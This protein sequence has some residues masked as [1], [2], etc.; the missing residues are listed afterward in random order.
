MSCTIQY[1]F[2]SNKDQEKVVREAL[3]PLIDKLPGWLRQLD[4][5][6]YNSY[7]GD[8]NCP[9]S[10]ESIFQYR[11]AELFIYF[12]FFSNTPEQ[13]H[14]ILIH[15]IVHLYSGALNRYVRN[16]LLDYIEKQNSDLAVS[17]QREFTDTNEGF[18]EDM[19]HLIS[20]LFP[21]ENQL[22]LNL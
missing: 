16:R 13:M 21:S 4:V 6:S 18:T 9:C 17:L 7:D 5:S 8:P 2:F 15:E 22:T 1:N 10:V 20:T 14:H 3:A 12:P 11:K 19:A